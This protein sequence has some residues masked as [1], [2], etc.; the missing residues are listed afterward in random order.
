ML[1]VS[2]EDSACRTKS[3]P[4]L[5][6]YKVFHINQST[7]IK[8]LDIEETNSILEPNLVAETIIQN[9]ISKTGVTFNVKASN[10][11][12]YIPTLD[13]ITVPCIEQYSSV[14]DYYSTIFHELTHSTGHKDTLGRLIAP[15][16]ATETNMQKKN[17][18]PK[19]VQHHCAIY[20]ELKRLKDSKILLY[21]YRIGLML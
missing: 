11:A 13:G 10:K 6:Y 12:F 18:L 8:P 5:R 16:S 21:I 3:I 20:V 19:L 1:N 14:S 4:I 15:F 9:Y 17:L 2:D 7:G